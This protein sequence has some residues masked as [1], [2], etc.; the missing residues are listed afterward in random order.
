MYRLFLLVLLLASPAFAQPGAQ[1]RSFAET[2]A[3]F[4]DEHTLIVVRI[5][6]G[7]FGN[8]VTNFA[9][10]D[11]SFGSSVGDANRLGGWLNGSSQ[12]KSM[13]TSRCILVRWWYTRSHDK[14]RSFTISRSAIGVSVSIKFAIRRASSFTPSPL[15]QSNT[16]NCFSGVCCAV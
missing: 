12:G 14:R 16:P 9:H 8:P 1:L 4:I 2:A 10:S 3:P 13:F 7:V 11:L 15:S 5:D 6:G